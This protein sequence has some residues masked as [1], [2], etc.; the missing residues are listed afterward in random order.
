MKRVNQKEEYFDSNH[1]GVFQTYIHPGFLYRF[2]YGNL[3]KMDKEFAANENC[4]GCATCQKVCPIN[5]ITMEENKPVWN[6]NNRCQVCL[7]Y[8]DWCPK[9]AIVHPST[10]AGVKRYH[11]PNVTVKK[12]S[13]LGQKYKVEVWTLNRVPRLTLNKLKKTSKNALKI[14]FGYPLLIE[15]PYLWLTLV[16]EKHDFHR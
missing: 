15:A 9:E 16:K 5:N 2:L 8:H 4:I 1:T 7:A 14:I 11:N 10:K 6:K 12:L 13:A 3:K